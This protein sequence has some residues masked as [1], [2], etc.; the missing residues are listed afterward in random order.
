LFA[1]QLFLVNEALR[2]LKL[3][4][5][6]AF[7]SGNY[8]CIPTDLSLRLHRPCLFLFHIFTIFYFTLALKT[9]CLTCSQMTDKNSFTPTVFLFACLILD[10]RR[11]SFLCYVTRLRTSSDTA[12]TCRGRDVEFI[13]IRST[14]P[15]TSLVASVIQGRMKL[16]LIEN[17]IFAFNNLLKEAVSTRSLLSQMYSMITMVRRSSFEK[18]S[19][20]VL[21]VAPFCF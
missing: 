12:S 20:L 15:I 2:C 3:S 19:E 21:A 1:V 4:E 18:V 11:L 5:A 16:S 10:T 13:F 9:T 8:F 7:N 6:G 14:P 17:G